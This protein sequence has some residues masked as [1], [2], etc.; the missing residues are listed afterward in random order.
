MEVPIGISR[1]GSS[2]QRSHL[3]YW[4]IE[5]IIITQFQRAS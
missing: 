3:G 1:E 4:Y 5:Q 2:I